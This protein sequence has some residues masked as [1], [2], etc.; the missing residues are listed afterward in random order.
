MRAERRPAGEVD[1]KDTKA[2]RCRWA[3][4]PELLVPKFEKAAQKGNQAST[5][6]SR[7]DDRAETRAGTS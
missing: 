5:A 4:V 1:E 7:F 2:R 3:C 6:V